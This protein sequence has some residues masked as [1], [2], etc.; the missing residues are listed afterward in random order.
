MEEVRESLRNGADLTDLN[1]MEL[2]N[3]EELQIDD[4]EP[5]VAEIEAFLEAVRTGDRPAIDATAGFVNVRTAE[6][7]VRAIGDS[8]G[9]AR[10]T[11]TT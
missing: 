8:L 7:I 3:S 9:A 5:I 10:T 4:S 11:V 6:R 2:V 1:W